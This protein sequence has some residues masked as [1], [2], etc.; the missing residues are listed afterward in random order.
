MQVND[1]LAAAEPALSPVVGLA[2]QGG[3]PLTAFR[4][5]EADDVGEL[6]DLHPRIV[7]TSAR[8]RELGTRER[9]LRAR[10]QTF[11]A[12]VR[13]KRSRVRLVRARAQ[14]IR[15]RARSFR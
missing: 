5:D 1:A 9:T 6:P 11:R 13:M 14:N 12:R 2:V 15:A 3:G 7:S 8:E 4:T 10:A